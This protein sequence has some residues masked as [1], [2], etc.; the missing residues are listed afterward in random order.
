[1]VAQRRV[2]PKYFSPSA[3]SSVIN[4]SWSHG[5][6]NLNLALECERR[7]NNFYSSGFL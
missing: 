3:F 7:K 4:I 2:Y 1:L 5:A 6:Q